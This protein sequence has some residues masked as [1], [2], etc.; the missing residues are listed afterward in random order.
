M[1]N[2]LSGAELG[3]LRRIVAV[4]LSNIK[5]AVAACQHASRAPAAGLLPF[6]AN[7]AGLCL[8]ELPEDNRGSFLALSD[9][10]AQVAPL[11]VR[12]PEAGRV[13]VVIGCGPEAQHVHTPIRLLR[14]SV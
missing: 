2:S 5:D 9:L 11:L 8:R 13:A 6:L 10:G 1:L 4:H 3:H 7:F 12:G 14:L